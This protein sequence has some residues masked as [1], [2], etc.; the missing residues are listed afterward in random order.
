MDAFLKFENQEI[1]LNISQTRLIRIRSTCDV[2]LNKLEIQFELKALDH[3]VSLELDSKDIKNLINKT[4]DIENALKVHANDVTLLHRNLFIIK[5]QGMHERRGI[6]M[7]KN[8]QLPVRI[9]QSTLE[10]LI[11][12][13]TKLEVEYN[14]LIQKLKGKIKELI[15]MTRANLKIK[16]SGRKGLIWM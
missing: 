10:R 5:L 8:G 2:S 15:T 13:K 9:M 1:F 6:S 4:N 12:N 3:G 14:D 7:T 11:A 16:D